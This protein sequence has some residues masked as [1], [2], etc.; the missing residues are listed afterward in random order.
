MQEQ[1]IRTSLMLVGDELRAMGI[2]QP[3]QMLLIG[4]AYMLTQLHNRAVTRDVDVIV[5]Q[6]EETSDDYRL[7][8]QAI[9]FVARDQG[10]NP[11]WLSDNIAQFLQSTG[12]VPDGTLWLSQGGLEVYIPDAGYILATKLLAGREKDVND[13]EALLRHLRIT[14]RKQ[15]KKILTTYLARKTR[16]DYAQ[17][18][19]ITLDLFFDD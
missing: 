5:L 17:D 16:R 19:Q 13:I 11:A 14:T 9:Q 7:L 8:K 2:R 6:P 10:I 12:N 1:E 18:I 4:G 3:V 15:A